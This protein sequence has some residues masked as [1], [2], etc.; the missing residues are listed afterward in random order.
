MATT[1][2][3]PIIQVQHST[4]DYR[5]KVSNKAFLIK[6]NQK[7]NPL[8]ALPKHE[9]GSISLLRLSTNTQTQN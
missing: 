8:Q 7:G 5:L 2:I 3:I 9:M 6:L 1:V 4:D